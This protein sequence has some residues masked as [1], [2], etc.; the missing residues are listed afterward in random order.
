M[1]KQRKMDASTLSDEELV[2]L[3]TD[4]YEEQVASLNDI[5]EF[6][7]SCK[8]VTGDKNVTMEVMV[9]GL[10]GTPC[11]DDYKE[12]RIKNIDAVVI[13]REDKGK[14][15]FKLAA[16]ETIALNTND[17]IVVYKSA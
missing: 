4:A 5:G 10:A 6:E 17:Y 15:K 13:E 2:D 11:L 16:K 8:R 3:F 9:C 12:M 14:L 1:S 7:A